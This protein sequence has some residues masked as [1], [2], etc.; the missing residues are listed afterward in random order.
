MY[1]KIDRYIDIQIYRYI[2]SQIHRCIDIQM[3]RYLNL[4][5]YRYIDIQ[6]SKYLDLQLYKNEQLN[7]NCFL[8][9][10]LIS[11][12]FADIDNRRIVNI[13]SP[14]ATS[15]NHVS[16]LCANLSI[17]CKSLGHAAILFIYDRFLL[18]KCPAR[19]L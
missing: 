1:I 2:D 17:S 15:M 7:S 4:Q 13:N 12:K 18:K 8:T 3:Y 19:F 9:V 14:R 16:S 11:I 10:C 6:I 5:A